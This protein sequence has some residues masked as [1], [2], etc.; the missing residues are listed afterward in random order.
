M[1]AEPQTM[2]EQDDAGRPRRSWRRRTV[3]GGLIAVAV[4]LALVLVVALVLQTEWG[5]GRVQS[6]AVGQIQELL[7][8]GATVSVDRLEGNFL[9]GARMLGLEIERGGETV[10]AIDTV[11]AR[12]RLLTLLRNRLDVGELYAAGVRVYARQYAD[13]TWNVAR[14]LKPAPT[15][16]A[17]TARASEFVVSIGEA[18]LRR[19]LAEVHFYSP[20]VDS[21]LAVGG[22]NADLSGFRT[23]GG[24]LEATVDTLFATVT[25]A[26]RPDPVRLAAQGAFDQE[27]AR[28]DG[29]LITSDASDVRASGAVEYGEGPLT[30]DLD[31]LASPLDFADLRAFVPLPLYGAAEIRAQAQG[32]PDDVLARLNAEFDHGGTINLNGAFS[33]DP[34]G[35]VRYAA[36]G[37][38]RD[39]DP[40]ALLN[41]PSLAG[42]L[43]ADLDVDLGGPSLER[44]DGRVDLKVR[45]SRLGE[46]Q[47][48][49]ADL[50]GE[51][52][53]GRLAF[54]LGGAV[55]GARV[56]AEGSARP[57]ADVPTYDVR[58]EASGVDL[59]A[60]LR[61]PE[62]TGRVERATFALEGRGFDTQTAV[63][64][65]SVD[66]RGLVVG[67]L[68]I[69]RAA[70]DVGLRDGALGFDAEVALAGGGGAV[71]AEGSVRP[72]AEPLSYR[73]DRG[74]LRNLDLAALTGDT[75]HTDLSGT[76]SLAG[77][78]TDPQAMAL[79]LD[80]S[81]RDARYDTFAIPAA[82]LSARLDGGLLAFDVD[83]DLAEAGRL[84][85]RGSARPFAEPL[86][87]DARGT[88]RNLDLAALTGDPAQSSDLSGTF[89][90]AGTGTDPQ[91]LALDLRL[92]LEGSRY[93]QQEITR[94]TA[95]GSLRRGTLDLS[96]DATTP[97]GALAFTV[98]GRPFDEQA[99]LRFSE[100]SFRGVNLALI[101][102]NPA[103]QTS[104][105]GRIELDAAGF[106]LQTSTTSGR[107]VLEPSRINGAQLDAGTVA[108]DLRQGYAEAEAFLDFERGAARLGFTGR[109]FDD[110]PTYALDGALDSLDVAALAGDARAERTSVT[111]AFDLE[112]RGLDPETMT[113][114][115]TLRGG[116]SRLVGAT[117]DTLATT[118]ALDASVLTVDDLLLRSSLA[119]ATGS[120]RIALFGAS[121]TEESAFAFRADIKDTE[122]LNAFLAEPLTF[123][124]GRVRGN[125]AGRPGEPLRI[126]AEADAE[127][128]AYGD[129]V[130]ASS[131]EV[132]FNGIYDPAA[133]AADTTVFGLG[134]LGKARV[135]F[136][137]LEAGGVMIQ[138]TDVDLTYDGN[139]L[140]A[141]GRLGVDQR[142]DLAF[143]LRSDLDPEQ[144]RITLETLDMNV[145]GE[146]WRLLDE[147]V[148]S[149]GERIRF[150]NLLLYS[151]AQ[152]IAID[153]VVDLDGEQ[154]LVLTVED[155]EVGA[156]T[157]LIGYDGVGGT[158]T[159]TLVM[160]GPAEDP[161]IAGTLR[162]TDL[163]SGGEPV[164]ALDVEVD[165]ARFRL[166]LDALL[167]HESGRTL[168]AEGYLPLAFQLGGP[169]TEA[170]PSSDVD[171][172]VRADSFPVAWAEP[173]LPRR[174]FTEVGGAL[175]ID[176]VVTGTQS[177]PRL[178]GEALLSDGVLGLEANGRVIRNV[179]VPAT[180]DGNTVRLRG[181]TAGGE[182]EGTLA[183]EG[184]I[185][186]PKLSL[187]EL[188]IAI[189]MDDFNAIETP[190]YDELRLSTPGMPLL[191]EGTTDRP[192]LT[193]AVTLV[194]GDIYLT[195]E[196]TGPD[197]EEVE[198]TPLQIQEV[199]ATF[200]L[201]VT[202][203]DTAR[204]V[205]VE[206]LALDLDVEIERN[207]WLRSRKNPRLDIE[208][209]GTVLA[210]KDPGGEFEVFR[211][212]T[213]NRGRI[214]TLGRNFQITSGSLSFNGPIPETYVDITA[215]YTVPSRVSNE[216][217]ATINLTFR[218]RM[219][220]NP[221]LELTSD[222]PM[223]NTDVIAYIATGRPA[224]EA[225]QGAGVANLLAAN[226]GSIIEGVAANSLGLD[227]VEVTQ[228]ADNAI[229]VTF[230]RY[231]TNRAFLQASQVITPGTG[232]RR[233]DRD[234]RFPELTLEY[235][236]VNWLMLR[237]ERS[238]VR[239][240]GG[241]LQ[242]EYAY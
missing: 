19:G 226:I 117:V 142:R 63:A 58:G 29:L 193:G 64:T 164:G 141:E 17:D 119:D 232:Q 21:V 211:T 170:L 169:I 109:P 67:D 7:D 129:V 114:A 18:R 73:V 97:E 158:L 66:V 215:A 239:G 186:L 181:A 50:V 172:V 93:R 70:G 125:V 149:Y 113:L 36:E 61:D 189:E 38:I 5:R 4:V 235:R 221:E 11:Y 138:N 33:A 229:V 83:A 106:D 168:T 237:L 159:T 92:D 167:T 82:D 136:G 48:Q 140:L 77:A 94:G 197:I 28:I 233:G 12:Y 173:F 214:E 212:I 86:A 236:L 230:G 182:G 234:S 205:F 201:R 176:L 76:F 100:S 88:V 46:Q 162:I 204:S 220:E 191:F 207:V 145:D 85:A 160:T 108:F 180:F 53:S 133:A 227:V 184:T 57:F 62:Q 110:V 101:L 84:S 130:R 150:R 196:L 219:A 26:T 127:Q 188:A 225:F 123:Q 195:E 112:G 16:E 228:R 190:T 27:R 210:Q 218:G 40:G 111:L 183:A 79:T 203:A 132:R 131:A 44:V 105:N 200:G 194:S 199:E 208:F 31:L 89:D 80:A 238:N 54:T 152:Q 56:L 30:F 128:F 32:T 39:F 47:I 163:V 102:D 8:E 14:V 42:D 206:N 107:V 59:A 217:E 202:E 155:V 144:N 134:L 242:A 25:P 45:G 161:E 135:R 2:P 74:T 104:L 116:D 60:L 68:A 137:F 175:T 121:R 3:H 9:T 192:R 177:D 90:V 153:G 156:F 34:D 20:R 139:D 72:F 143:R 55:P 224:G 154:N 52:T 166:T 96:V 157:D 95:V 65:G 43:T 146:Q 198:L 115:G 78:G 223:E 22:L 23:G 87:Y 49:R 174:T 1:A 99:T 216:P 231:L 120:G 24:A 240:E 51:F 10:I 151:D 171:F 165:Y 13:S 122:P 179:T 15:T 6:I 98:S 75:T 69:E 41:D 147:A 222:P 213:V 37:T 148:I 187:G 103:L 118:F 126:N 35:P 124:G 81:L 241:G 71:T 91:T 185:T 178:S 209:S